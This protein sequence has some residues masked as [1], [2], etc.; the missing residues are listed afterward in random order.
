M[1]LP[2]PSRLSRYIWA[3]FVFPV[4]S[5]FRPR[6]SHHL[7][8]ATQVD[9]RATD[10]RCRA[11][12][13]CRAARASGT[14]ALRIGRPLDDH[15]L[16]DGLAGRRRS[17]ERLGAKEDPLLRLESGEGVGGKV[18]ASRLERSDCGKG[19]PG[20]RRRAVSSQS[21]KEPAPT[22]VRVRGSFS[23]ANSPRLHPRP[24]QALNEEDGR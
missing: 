5:L 3:N 1:S 13:G 17:D 21:I 24:R 8:H 23:W 15:R 4:G 6:V 22:N 7:G 14:P 18:T 2:F 20:R 10:D 19:I 16:T 12:G 9:R 11:P